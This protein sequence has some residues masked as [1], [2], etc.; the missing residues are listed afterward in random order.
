MEGCTES[1][2]ISILVNRKSSIESKP[3]RGLTQGDPLAPL[4]FLIVME[5][6]AGLDRQ[7]TEKIMLEGLKVNM[8][9]FADDMF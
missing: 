5:R 6:L 7:A 3:S 8:L 9:Q 2:T 4:L 1:S